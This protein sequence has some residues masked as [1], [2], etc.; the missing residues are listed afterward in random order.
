M[1]SIESSFNPSSNMN[2]RTQYKGLFQIGRDEWRQHGQ[3]NIYNAGDNAR[4][5]ASLINEHR[6]QFHQHFGRDPTAGELYM[7]H[8]QGL[9]FY[10]RGAMTNIGGNPYPG[11]HGPQSHGSFEA[12]WTRELEKRASR[13]G[14]DDETTKAAALHGAALRAH[15]GHRQRPDAPD[16]L[17]AG[18]RAGLIGQ[19]QTHKV[20]GNASVDIN[21]NGFPKGTATKTKM[22]GMFKELRLNRGRAAVLASQEG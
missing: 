7:M 20:E 15:F 19:P 5:M 18:Q 2:K 13:Y 16:L 12:G 8:Q 3:G 17:S 14:P 1:A 10:T 21:L 4:A 6:G 9:G 11:M 22:G